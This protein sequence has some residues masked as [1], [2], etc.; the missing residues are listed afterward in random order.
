MH[1]IIIADDHPIFRGGIKNI[2]QNMDDIEIIGE[3]ENGALAYHLIISGLPDIA[4]LDLEMPLLSGLEV[5]KKVLSE[6]NNTKFI[7]LT[8]H[9]EKHYFTEAME[10]G[11]SG[12]LLKDNAANDLVTCINEVMKGN[13]YV[14][15]DI[16]NYLI[17][18][19]SK[20]YSGDWHKINLL[21]TPTE[22]VVLK[23]IS[24]G[25]TSSE[26]ADLL[27]VSANTIDNH[28]S[29]LNKKLK[30]DGEKNAL[31]KYAMKIKD[32]LSV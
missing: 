17:E 29:N 9:K 15:K 1:K 3:A 31:L 21:L 16:E 23:L 14:S 13:K 30:L 26:I 25:K 11:V 27:F 20:E 8:M 32:L 7:I 5:S 10:C 6:K 22:K 24:E 2:L 4:I 19:E 18:H 12:Y 28:R